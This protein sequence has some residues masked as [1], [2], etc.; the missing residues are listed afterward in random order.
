MEMYY[1]REYTPTCRFLKIINETRK[2]KCILLHNTFP[3][4]TV[5]SFY[6]FA[7]LM[8]R[9]L[10]NPQLN[11]IKQ[12]NV[13]GIRA[14]NSRL[15]LDMS[16]SFNEKNRLYLDISMPFECPKSLP[17]VCLICYSLF[18]FVLRECILKMHVLVSSEHK[19]CQ[20]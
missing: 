16:R 8:F 5:V 11:K 17:I 19:L 9:K 20:I 18:V 1:V 15:Y 3:S 10:N 4:A 2:L 13:I 6:N 12:Q 14:F 7:F